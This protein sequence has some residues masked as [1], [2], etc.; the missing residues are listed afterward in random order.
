MIHVDVF[1]TGALSNV[2]AL[3]FNSYAKTAFS[4]AAIKQNE[5]DSVNLALGLE[6]CNEMMFYVLDLKIEPF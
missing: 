3:I 5:S 6:A 2:R 1:L 4:I